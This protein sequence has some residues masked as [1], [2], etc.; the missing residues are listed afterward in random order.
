MSKM[1]VFSLLA[2]LGGQF[3]VFA[4]VVWLLKGTGL[5]RDQLIPQI[6]AAE[7]TYS[8][9]KA[10]MAYWTL[11]IL[12]CFLYV[13]LVKNADL[14]TEIVSSQAVALMGISLLT[15][16][17]AAVVD[18]RQDTAEDQVNEALKAMGLSNSNDVRKLEARN[19][20]PDDGSKLD[21]YNKSVVGYR[22]EGFWNDLLTNSGGVGLHRLQAV[23]WTAVIGVL[24]VWKTLHGTGSLP[25][26]DNNL[27]AVMGISSAGY[28]GFKINEATN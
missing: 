23:I 4:V 7:R 24:F 14:S 13:V 11:T 8:L 20:T 15:A 9:A 2:V 1:D 27:L 21:F 5:L 6:P 22:T 18:A 17:G 16:G 26:L 3:V 10:Q 28:V 12:G 25:T 19:A